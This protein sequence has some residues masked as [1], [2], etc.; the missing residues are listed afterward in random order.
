[1]LSPN[2]SNF[3][4]F[5]P[6]FP[7]HWVLLWGKDSFKL[8][9]F[10]CLLFS[11]LFLEQCTPSLWNWPGS[12][13]GHQLLINRGI[14][15]IPSYT[16]FWYVPVMTVPPGLNNWLFGMFWYQEPCSSLS[17]LSKCSCFTIFPYCFRVI[18]KFI[19]N[20]KSNFRWD[21]T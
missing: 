21:Y 4:P 6:I 3:W 9:P 8:G 10:V 13:A 15:S 20:I 1:M 12:L 7:L 5:S 16:L 19:Q 2:S 14:C 11:A 18:S 17:K